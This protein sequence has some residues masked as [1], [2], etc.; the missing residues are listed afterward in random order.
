MT[1]EEIRELLEVTGAV[2]QGHFQLSSGVHSPTY[3]QCALLL[4]HPEHAARLAQA[5]ARRF[6][7]SSIDL[8]A[9]PAL[10]GVV[11]GY[12]LAR[13]LRARSIFA[14]RNTDG[15]LSLRRGFGVRPGERTLVAEDVVTT[16]ASTRETIEVVRQAGGQV[17]GVAALIDR[18]GGSIRF[19]VPLEALLVQ[20]LETFQP[21]ACPLCHDRVPLEKPGSRPVPP[22]AGPALP[23]AARTRRRA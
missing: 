17:I 7:E 2:R 22:S 8:V 5:L 15:R 19:G 18:S 1:P 23:A 6:A 10:G 4:Q 3:V 21:D 13:Q 14:E 11:L 12:E 20:S 9:G 16:G